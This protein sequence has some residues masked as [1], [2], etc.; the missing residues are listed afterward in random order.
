LFKIPKEQIGQGYYGIVYKVPVKTCI[1][2]IPKGTEYIA[3]KFERINLTNNNHTPQKLKETISIT[4]KIAELGMGPQLYDVF[5]V[6]SLGVYFI[7]KLYEYIEGNAWD[8]HKF[9]ST[10]AY[11]KAL[12]TLTKYVETFNKH[13]ILHRD[14][15][16]K[17][18]MITPSEQIYIIDFDLASYAENFDKESIAFFHANTKH[19]LFSSE[20]EIYTR[21]VYNQLIKQK[22][23]KLG[24]KTFK[25]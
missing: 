7:V 13:G 5:I 16:P 25:K 12:D 19:I 9:K 22:I 24:N 18:V 2:N 23:I 10:K 6:E 17:N 4:K 21:Y 3:M 15:H 1:Q 11:N 8:V 14:L 20:I